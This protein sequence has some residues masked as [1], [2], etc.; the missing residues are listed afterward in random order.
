[1][2]GP[3]PARMANPVREE[4]WGSISDLARLQG[5]LPTGHP[6]AELWMG[7]DPADPSALIGL[8]GT[9]QPLDRLLD[10]HPQTLLGWD[11][12]ARHGAR[13][14]YLLKLF[15]VAEP[16]PLGTQ[17]GPETAP[18]LLYA[19][20]PVDVLAGFRDADH[21]VDLLK[22]LDCDRLAPLV[23]VL[24]SGGAGPRPAAAALALLDDWP[25]EDRA[26]LVA[27]VAAGSR[28]VLRGPRS[29]GALDPTDRRAL[30][31]ALRLAARRPVDPLVV[32]PFLLDVVHLGPGETLFVPAMAPNACLAGVG[33]ELRA[34]SG[35][36]P[37]DGTGHGDGEGG[38]EPAGSPVRDVPQVRLGPHEVAWRPAEE[39]FQLS[40]LRPN[41]S[42]PIACY[43]RLSGPQVVLCTAGTVGVATSSYA[44]ALR[45]G[46][47]AFVGASGGPITLAGPG[48]V[49]RAA[50]G[51]PLG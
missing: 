13:L 50:V 5:R 40:R 18:R 41:G 14:P 48:E 42:T 17:P 46:E 28:R 39:A 33:L 35:T 2:L 15:A 6:E 25:G 31:W 32:T 19:L 29:A 16:L 21:A 49:F 30:I 23:E 38:H 37:H 51:E 8:D 36:G 11:V 43:P 1:M 20:R 27:D 47:S 3:W 9:L 10:R 4:A 7:A 45:P 22:R 24:T 12:L 44:L 26:A 34:A